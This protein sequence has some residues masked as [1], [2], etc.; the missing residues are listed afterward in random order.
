MFR[1]SS[2]YDAE[3]AP[4]QVDSELELAMRTKACRVTRYYD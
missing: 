3:R 2:K 1:S 4:S